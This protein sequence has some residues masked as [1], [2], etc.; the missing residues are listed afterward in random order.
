MCDK[1]LSHI[2]SEGVFLFILKYLF[3]CFTV[4]VGKDKVFDV[5]V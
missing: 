5:C 4:G 2:A 1:R 3:N